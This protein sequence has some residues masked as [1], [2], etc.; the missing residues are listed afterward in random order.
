MPNNSTRM[1]TSS[2]DTTPPALKSSHSTGSSER[3]AIHP[4]NRSQTTNA[5]TATHAA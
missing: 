5:V 3:F 1:G 2:A 4:P